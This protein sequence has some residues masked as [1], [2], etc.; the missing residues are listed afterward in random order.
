MKKEEIAITGTIEKT[1]ETTENR[2]QVPTSVKSVWRG[3]SMSTKFLN[4]HNYDVVWKKSVTLQQQEII[5]RRS[6]CVCR[7]KQVISVWKFALIIQAVTQ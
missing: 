1:T 3:C 2:K 4:V 6:A 5:K 7:Y